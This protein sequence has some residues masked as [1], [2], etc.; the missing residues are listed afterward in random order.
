MTDPGSIVGTVSLTLQVLQG[1]K[2][3]YTQFAAYHNEITAVVKRI[4]QV[5]DNVQLLE[6]V[7]ARLGRNEDALAAAVQANIATCRDAVSRLQMYQKKCG[8]PDHQVD[9]IKRRAVLIK[10]RAVF[11]FRKDTLEDIQ[12]LLDRLLENL[13]VIMQALQ[14]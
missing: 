6:N 12:R 8:E 9:S 2:T 7:V 10:R 11:P 13:Q 4:E 5:Q 14:L 3:Y 1:L